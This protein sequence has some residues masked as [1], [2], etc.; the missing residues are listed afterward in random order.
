MQLHLLAIRELF[1]RTQRMH[2]GVIIV[3]IAKQLTSIHR[4]FTEETPLFCSQIFP[5]E[6]LNTVS[7]GRS[8]SLV[9]ISPSS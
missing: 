6:P 2:S 5:I 7:T 1:D 9:S 8:L 4:Q 3:P